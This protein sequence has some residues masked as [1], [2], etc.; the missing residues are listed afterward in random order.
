MRVAVVTGSSSG[1]GAELVRT[2]RAQDWRV[3]GVSRRPSE[4]DEPEECDVGDRAAVEALAERVLARHPHID[5]LVNNA[6]F[7]G[8]TVFAGGDSDAIEA[9]LRTNYLGSVWVT[10]AFLPGLGRGSHIVNVVSIAGEVADGPYSATKHAQLAF[11]RSLAVELAP[12]GIA[13]HTVKPGLVET[14]GFPHRQRGAIARRLTVDPPFV[15]GRILG[16]IEHNH[17]EITVPRWYR[18][19]ALAQAVMPAGLTRARQAF[20]R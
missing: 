3:V 1:I 14:P 12:R 20:R 19:L 2:L 8:R 9:M 5:L 10:N 4:A 18:I 7:T 13:V 15:V 6:G 17:R 11:S 16:A